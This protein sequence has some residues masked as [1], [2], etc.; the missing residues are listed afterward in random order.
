MFSL[1]KLVASFKY[2][3]YLC[4]F[5]ETVQSKTLRKTS[6]T[7]TNP[8]PHPFRNDES[9]DRCII[10]KLTECLTYYNNKLYP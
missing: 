9:K 1:A 10:H 6:G 7:N 2:T 5:T 3:V 4:S 8:R